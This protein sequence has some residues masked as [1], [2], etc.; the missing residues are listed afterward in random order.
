MLPVFWALQVAGGTHRKDRGCK[1]RFRAVDQT[2]SFLWMPPTPAPALWAAERGGRPH[3]AEDERVRKAGHNPRADPWAERTVGGNPEWNGQGSAPSA[4][5]SRSTPVCSAVGVLACRSA[6]LTPLRGRRAVSP[7]ASAQLLG[8]LV[9]GGALPAG[10]PGVGILP[11]QEG[12]CLPSPA[13]PQY[14]RPP[15][16]GCPI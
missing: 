10:V 3:G 14:T 7:P 12:N 13:L 6:R 16:A 15:G 8:A 9:C 4:A 1:C 2:H 5:V 11:G